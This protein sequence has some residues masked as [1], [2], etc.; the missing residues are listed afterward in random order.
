MATL[1]LVVALATAEA[2]ESRRT[3]GDVV[4]CFSTAQD[5]IPVWGTTRMDVVVRN[6]GS[7]PALV[8][9]PNI[10]MP[11]VPRLCEP[12]SGYP[13]PFHEVAPGAT[14]FFSRTLGI[15]GDASL[16]TMGDKV[17]RAS[18]GVD[19]DGDRKADEAVVLEARYRVVEPP[20]EV[21]TIAQERGVE[22]ELCKADGA[23][24]ARV[25]AI[26]I[27]WQDLENEQQARVRESI[28]LPTPSMTPEEIEKRGGRLPRPSDPDDQ[29]RLEEALKTGP[30]YLR[31][32]AL[33]GKMGLYAGFDYAATVRAIDALLV[34]RMRFSEDGFEAH[35][36]G[37]PERR[38]EMTAMPAY[39]I[40]LVCKVF[41]D[42]GKSA[43]LEYLDAL[44]KEDLR[45]ADRAFLEEVRAIVVAA[46][47]DLTR[48]DVVY[49]QKGE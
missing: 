18:M 33:R 39:R 23:G 3:V 28:A 49:Q 2:G 21:L 38:A 4:L 10:D 36:G 35:W 41:L 17:V 44:A 8:T 9:E 47:D 31:W 46:P 37:E 7:R 42:N 26:A 27:P 22:V 45:C 25:K 48:G 34:R 32:E 12:S 29:K 16:S 15:A 43:A 13:P 14:W 11:G 40:K 19:L 1:A 5:D 6:G 20:A 24:G 30:A